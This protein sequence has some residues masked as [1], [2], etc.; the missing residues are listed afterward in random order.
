MRIALLLLFALP[1]GASKEVAAT[2]QKVRILVTE[3]DAELATELQSAEREYRTKLYDLRREKARDLLRDRL[4]TSEATRRGITV[5]ELVEAEVAAKAEK[6]GEAQ[7][8]EV[9]ERFKH[10]MEGASFEEVRSEI[11]DLLVS[12]AFE[13]RRDAFWAELWEKA[14]ARI[15]LEPMRV[16]VGTD[17]A[18]GWGPESAKVTIVVFADYE[19]PYC[20]KGAHSLNKVTEQFAKDVRVVYRDFPLD[21]HQS[22]VPAA[23]AARCAGAQGKYR[24]MHDAL[25]ASQRDLGERRIFEIAGELKLDLPAYTKCLVDPGI[26]AGVLADQ[27]AGAAVGVSGTPAFFINGI[28]LTGA[29]P[30]AS[31]IELVRAELGRK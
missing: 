16:K 25:Y 24:A 18:G 9:Y 30:A 2:A 22:A 4:L 23:I 17:G 29:R 3:V 8:R 6:P 19:C 11:D 13:E 28:P 14:G 26:A 12:R 21:F 31:F 20:A 7:A 27:E 10:K 15:T 1:A 5:K